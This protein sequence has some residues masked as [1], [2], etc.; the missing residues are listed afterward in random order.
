M[1]SKILKFKKII[2]VLISILVMILSYP[3]SENVLFAES[4]GIVPWEYDQSM[5]YKEILVSDFDHGTL[6]RDKIIDLG[7]KNNI[8]IFFKDYEIDNLDDNLGYYY[9]TDGK[10]LDKLPLT[11]KLSL[12]EFNNSTDYFSNNDKNKSLN[13]TSSK[14][15]RNSL[16]SFKN[17]KIKRFLGQLLVFGDAEDLENFEDDLDKIYGSNIDFVDFDSHSFF[18]I[19]LILK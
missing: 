7:K 19:F 15:Y 18:M 2:L 4:K 1:A 12:D 16:A 6:L 9:L 14:K 11:E 3:L 8:N 10:F 17:Y 5:S 13:L